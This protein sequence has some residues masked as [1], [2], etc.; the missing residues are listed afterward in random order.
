[1]KNFMTIKRFMTMVY[2]VCLSVIMTPVC[3]AYIDPATTSYL[4]QIIAGVVIALGTVVGI[5][6]NK[7]KRLFKKKKGDA[8]EASV[9]MIKDRS[10]E[11]NTV[12]ADDLLDD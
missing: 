10:E 12:T 9:E 11:K 5:Y 6:W 8:E 2:I 3:Y 4:I 1:M 7:L